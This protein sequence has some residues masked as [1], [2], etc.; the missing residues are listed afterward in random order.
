MIKE[1]VSISKVRPSKFQGAI[2]HRTFSKHLYSL[3]AP[4]KHLNEVDVGNN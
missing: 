3:F 4:K 1:G 2:R